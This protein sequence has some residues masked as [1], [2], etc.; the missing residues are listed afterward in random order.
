MGSGNSVQIS[1]NLDRVNPFYFAAESVSGMV[2]VD[3]RGVK[4]KVDEVF[5]E[6]KGEIGYTTTRT[7]SDS[8]MAHHEQRPIIIPYHF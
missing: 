8:R 6:L 4:V 3:I 1:I 5:I 2:N 7:V